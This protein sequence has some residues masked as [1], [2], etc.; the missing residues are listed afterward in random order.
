MN[1]KE[2]EDFERW[3]RHGHE[4]GW[5]ERSGSEIRTSLG[6]QESERTRILDRSEYRQNERYGHQNDYEQRFGMG[7]YRSGIE[8]QLNN[9][10]ELNRTIRRGNSPMFG[11]SMR[12]DQLDTFDRYGEQSFNNPL[13]SKNQSCNYSHAGRGPK[14]F[15]RSDERIRE[16]AHELLTR[17]HEI[18][19]TDVE[20]EVKDGEVTLTGMV[21]DRNSK[22]LAED[23]VDNIYGVKQVHNQIRVNKNEGGFF[24]NNESKSESRNLVRPTAR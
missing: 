3:L 19:A 16:I 8:Q 1:F 12:D 17:H 23:L 18:D 10:F 9:D 15:Q 21:N 6:D 14:G 4:R 5:L 13:N 11:S 7:G 22:R 20:I 2:R 24:L